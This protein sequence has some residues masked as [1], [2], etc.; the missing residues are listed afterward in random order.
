MVIFLHKGVF[1]LRFVLGGVGAESLIFDENS[2]IG[3]L[4]SPIDLG[5]FPFMLP[6]LLPSLSDP[7]QLP[8]FP[9]FKFQLFIDR[10]IIVDSVEVILVL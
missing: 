9:S 10:I 5:L 6:P 4:P 3:H 7:R 1:C 8:I 2:F